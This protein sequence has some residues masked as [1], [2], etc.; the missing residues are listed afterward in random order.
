MIFKL[1]GVKAIKGGPENIQNSQILKI[2]QV[3]P[4]TYR[5]EFSKTFIEIPVWQVS[6]SLNKLEQQS[7]RAKLLILAEL[8]EISDVL[9]RCALCNEPRGTPKKPRS[10]EFS[11]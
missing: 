6:D 4:T 7:G 2:A 1:E 8:Q 10:T 5:S 9:Q 3:I 11:L